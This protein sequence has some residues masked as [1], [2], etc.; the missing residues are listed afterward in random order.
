MS[1]WISLVESDR[2]HHEINWDRVHCSWNY[3]DMLSTLP[4]GYERDWQGKQA[5]DM[6]KPIEDS[7]TAL[8]NT[9][10]DYKKYE[11]DPDHDCGTIEGCQYILKTCL[12][13]FRQ[14]PKGIIILD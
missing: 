9:P 5:E 12:K 11:V 1:Y 2:N 3:S 7:L 10:E 13:G 6:I 8:K 4:C 14:Y